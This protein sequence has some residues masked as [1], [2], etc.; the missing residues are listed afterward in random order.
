MS[1]L[2]HQITA[3]SEIA[4]REFDIIVKIITGLNDYIAT[5]LFVVTTGMFYGDVGI[6]S[7]I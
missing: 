2:H 4:K 5:A 1:V 7:H 6:K 3:P